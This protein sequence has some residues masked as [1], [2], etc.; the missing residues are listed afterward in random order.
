MRIFFLILSFIVQ[1]Y[2][3]QPFLRNWQCIGIQDKIDFSKPYSANIG[4][5][6]LV[7]WQTRKYPHPEY[8]ATVNIC[9]HMGSQLNNAKITD[10]GCLKCPYHGYEYSSD[11]NFGQVMAHQGKLFWAYKPVQ[12][13]PYSVPFFYSP[14]YE[15]STF[16]M[17]MPCSLQDSAYNTMDLRHPEYVHGGIFGFGNSIPPT[18]VRHYIHKSDHIRTNSEYVGVSFEYASTSLATKQFNAKTSRNYH[19]YH[20]PSFSWSKVSIRTPTNKNDRNDQDKDKDEDE[21]DDKNLIIGV[22]LLPIAPK[23]T[24]WYITICHNY[25]KSELEK[26]LMVGLAKTILTQ[27]FTQMQMQAPENKLK[28]TVMFNKTFNDEDPILWLKDIFTNHYQYPDINECVE[29]YKEGEP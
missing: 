12:P 5:L 27:D 22:H 16:E 2:S 25:F 7:V 19:E 4:D 17:T 13:I 24:K 26:Y 21:D 23:Q 18:N 10:N 29:L 6:P 1:S 28:Q 8:S 11:E 15:T 3:F 9:K 20:Y 14:D